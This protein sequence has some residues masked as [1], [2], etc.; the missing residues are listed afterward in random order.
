[1]RFGTK[2]E[3]IS[4]PHCKDTDNS[5]KGSGSDFPIG[6]DVFIK[7][8]LCDNAHHW[9]ELK[10]YLEAPVL[11]QEQDFDVLG[12]WRENEVKYPLFGHSKLDPDT[13]ETLMCENNWLRNE[14]EGKTSC[15]KVVVC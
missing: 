8:E 7:S 12:W 11:P 10:R 9:L 4:L 3:A 2:P 13:L 1:M 5:Y 6:Y 15:F 14:T